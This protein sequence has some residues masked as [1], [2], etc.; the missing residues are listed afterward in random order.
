MKSIEKLILISI[1][2]ILFSMQAFSLSIANE[3]NSVVNIV[4]FD[5]MLFSLNSDNFDD[6]WKR[7]NNNLDNY[8]EVKDYK[9]AKK[10]DYWDETLYCLI[11]DNHQIPIGEYTFW[12]WED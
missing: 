8:I 11:T 5:Q 12:D 9:L 2:L 3:D 4:R 1:F 10:T 6:K 7:W